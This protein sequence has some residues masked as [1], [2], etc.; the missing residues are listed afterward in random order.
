MGFLLW[1]CAAVTAVFILLTL[2]QTREA[3][4]ELPARV[5]IQFDFAGRPSTYGPR[6]MIW[7]VVGV[8]LLCAAIFVLAGYAIAARL[9]GTHGSVRGLALLA[10]IVTAMLWRAQ[11]LLL[12]VARAPAHRVPM[13]AFWLFYAAGLAAILAI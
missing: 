11:V 1:A 9:P 5:P 2:A 4:P 12:D 10:P 8:Q 3:Y 7:I 13:G 6:P